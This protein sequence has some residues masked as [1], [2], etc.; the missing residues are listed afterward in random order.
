MKKII[1]AIT[2]AMAL[3]TGCTVRNNKMVDVV[4]LDDYSYKVVYE[5]GKHEVH[6]FDTELEMAETYTDLWYKIYE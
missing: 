3:M 6:T 4:V 5:S 2:I 1:I